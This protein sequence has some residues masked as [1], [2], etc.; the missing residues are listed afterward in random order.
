MENSI[1]VNVLNRFLQN[2]LCKCHELSVYLSARRK[3]SNRINDNLIG[4]MKK[5]TYHFAF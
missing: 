4:L 2:Q 5:V 3:Q 1:N